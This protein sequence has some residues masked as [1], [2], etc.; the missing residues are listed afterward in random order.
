MLLDDAAEGVYEVDDKLQ[1][2]LELG[3]QALLV[4][5]L[6]V[7]VVTEAPQLLGA[8]GQ[9]ASNHLNSR[10][11]ERLGAPRPLKRHD[12]RRVRRRVRRSASRALVA[13]AR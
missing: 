1:L 2:L 13:G 7:S 12:A 11:E 4:L 8:T 6:G 5:H 10:A 9:A 3:L